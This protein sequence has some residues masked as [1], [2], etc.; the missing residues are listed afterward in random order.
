MKMA[1][2]QRANAQSHTIDLIGKWKRFT[3]MSD[4]VKEKIK[5]YTFAEG[6]LTVTFDMRVNQLVPKNG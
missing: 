3:K 4:W 2:F 6:Q 5:G 1:Y